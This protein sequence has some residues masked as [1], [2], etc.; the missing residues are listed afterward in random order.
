M[1]SCATALATS[2]I[3]CAA[4]TAGQSGPSA[5][6]VRGSTRSSV[7]E[8]VSITECD[9]MRWEAQ[10]TWLTPT[11]LGRGDHGNGHAV[12]IDSGSQPALTLPKLRREWL[13]ASS[14]AAVST[15][16][17]DLQSELPHSALEF[18]PQP[19]GNGSNKK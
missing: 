2:L 15:S 6:V 5:S 3:F 17:S 9:R 12:H 16:S 11:I 18:L 1:R 10:Q 14:E 13:R 8:Q 7:T 19:S 4:V